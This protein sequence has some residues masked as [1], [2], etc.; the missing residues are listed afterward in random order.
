[1]MQAC[2]FRFPNRLYRIAIAAIFAAVVI[3]PSMA[4]AADVSNDTV[5]ERGRVFDTV[6]YWGADFSQRGSKLNDF[7]VSAGAVTAL[8][9][10]ILT[11]GWTVTAN[12]GLARSV[13]PLSRT[14]GT[15]GS[16]LLGYH[17]QLP[18]VYLSLSSGVNVVHNDKRPSGGVGDGTTWGAIIQ[19]GLE[20]R[21]IDPVFIQSYG[22]YSTANRQIY[23]HAKLGYK[24]SV[25]RFGPEFTYSDSRD[26]SGARLRYGVFLGGIPLGDHIK[27]I[28][29]GGY[30]QNQGIRQR[31]GF[32]A[33]IGFYTQLAI[34]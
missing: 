26:S 8:N 25:L 6:V 5:P 9:G 13:A 15:Y 31:D 23:L 12:A 1:M 28:V 19:Y 11:S 27:M 10:N 29:S 32:Y 16:L 24:G 22:A 20:L 21:K 3:L 4:E 17:W 33:A 18:A 14:N 30:Q 2:S 34:R 7:G